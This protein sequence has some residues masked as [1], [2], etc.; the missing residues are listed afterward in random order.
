MIK[1]YPRTIKK[2]LSFSIGNLR[3]GIDWNFFV[4][5][6]II[7]LTSCYSLLVLLG[8]LVMKNKKNTNVLRKK[9]AKVKSQSQQVSVVCFFSQAR[10]K[11]K[12]IIHFVTFT[13][14]SAND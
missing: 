14:L 12:L 3:I 7:L 13:F 1:N 5:H 2:F 11:I 10:I 8:L 6:K 4:V 9:V